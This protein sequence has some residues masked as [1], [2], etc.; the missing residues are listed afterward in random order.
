MSGVILIRH[1]MPNVQPGVASKLWGLT[2]SSREDCVLLAHALP[3]GVAGIWSSDEPKARETAEVI[4]LRL[5][6]PVQIDGAFAEVDRPEIWDRDYREVAAEYLNG[7]IEAGW[8]DPAAV[9]RRFSR[10]IEKAT[11]PDAADVVVV[12]HGLAMT[13]W[14][15][16]QTTLGLETWWRSL[17]LPDAWRV[18]LQ[19]GTLEHIWLGGAD[20]A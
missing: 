3:A 7:T 19:S 14:L 17:S 18:E 10:G 6:L 5:G 15:A 20:P 12:N 2:E 8:E 16:T 11:R 9:V 4:G 13:L 1:A